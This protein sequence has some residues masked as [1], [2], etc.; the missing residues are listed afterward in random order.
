MIDATDETF[1]QL[2]D[3]DKPVIVDFWAPWCQPCKQIAPA[4]DKLEQENP[5]AVFIKVNVDLCNAT[6]AKYA[7]RGV[8]TLIAFMNKQ[9][10]ATHVG[11]A[12]PAKLKAFIE[13][14]E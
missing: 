9:V 3:T 8:P 6:A 12:N 11:A 10:V 4:L 2:I 1:A 14:N 5:D 13:N 7:I